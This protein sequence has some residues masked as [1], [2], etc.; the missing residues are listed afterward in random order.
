M[1]REKKRRSP[2]FWLLLFLGQLAAAGLF[3]LLGFWLDSL[4]FSGGGQGHGI[5]VFS[6][7]FPL[8]AAAVTVIVL[9]VALVGF[10]R[11]LTRRGDET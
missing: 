7:L 4:L 9:I 5:P 1:K 6:V 10:I 3:T 11:A 8:I 2:L